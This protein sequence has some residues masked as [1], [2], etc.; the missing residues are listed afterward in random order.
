MK[1]RGLGQRFALA[2]AFAS[3]AAGLATA[4][5]AAWWAVTRG[6][7]DP[8]FASLAAGT[9]FLFGA[10]IVLHVIGAADLPDLRIGGKPER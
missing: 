10:G 9:V 5:G 7:G 2:C 1:R 6:T 3:Y 8:I 4:A